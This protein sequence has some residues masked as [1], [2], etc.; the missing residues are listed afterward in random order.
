[1]LQWLHSMG[2]PMDVET[3]RKAAGQGHLQVL[4]WAIRHGGKPAD[5]DEGCE[6]ACAAADT[7]Q[8]EVLKWMSENLSPLAWTTPE[9]VGYDVVK[10]AAKQ[11]RG[12]WLCFSGWL[13]VTVTEGALA[14]ICRTRRAVSRCLLSTSR[15]RH[16]PS[17]QQTQTAK[18][19][20][21]GPT[22]WMPIPVRL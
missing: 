7:R 22:R 5:E 2:C 6:V 10:V 9:H 1:M 8:L 15:G 3:L 11:R 13:P 18:C 17:I 19:S 12:I 4:E 16:A 14:V 20:M 21:D